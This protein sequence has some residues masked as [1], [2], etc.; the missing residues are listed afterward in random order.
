MLRSDLSSKVFPLI[1]AVST[2]FVS[3]EDCISENFLLN[4]KVSEEQYQHICDS[5]DI[6]QGT[7]PDELPVNFYKRCVRSHS[8]SLGNLLYN[9]KQTGVF[10]TCQKN[11]IV[12]STFR[13]G[14]TRM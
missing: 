4:F 10:L 13:K 14:C 8:K 2:D 7:V 1:F 3:M 9:I 12:S 5:L 11:S 6:R